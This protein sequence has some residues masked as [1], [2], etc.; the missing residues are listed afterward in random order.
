MA[1]AFVAVALTAAGLG[2]VINAPPATAVA[3][4]L[5]RDI[6][7]GN[8]ATNERELSI[9]VDPANPN[10]LMAGSDRKSVV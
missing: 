8:V 1:K 2:G 9:A 7:M 3:N 5:I 10:R 4:P 6:S